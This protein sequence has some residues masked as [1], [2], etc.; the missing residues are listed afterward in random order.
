[1]LAAGRML[2][3][4]MES[5]IAVVVIKI[6]MEIGVMGVR[7][8]VVGVKQEPVIQEDVMEPMHATALVD[9]GNV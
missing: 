5:V 8:S 1:M 7:R 6:A 4:L 3:V 2:I 9:G